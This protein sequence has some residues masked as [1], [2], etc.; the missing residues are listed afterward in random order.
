MGDDDRIGENRKT[1]TRDLLSG[2][3]VG[4]I[5][6]HQTVAACFRSSTLTTAQPDNDQ[7]GV[8]SNAKRQQG[9]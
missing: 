4:L 1:E 3:I 6:R 5:L 7:R 9:E 2:E 8:K